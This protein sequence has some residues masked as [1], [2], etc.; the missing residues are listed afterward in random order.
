[1]EAIRKQ[2]VGHFNDVET[3]LFCDETKFSVN[4]GNH[5][6]AIIYLAIA[7]HKSQA[8][9]LSEALRSIL[10]IHQVKA[11]V[12]HATKIFN[13][14]SPRL[15]LMTDLTDCIIE[16]KLHCFCFKYD[17]DLLFEMTKRLEYL[18]SDIHHF[19]R[20]E[21]QAL[22]YFITFFNTFLIYDKPQ[23]LKPQ[24]V[25]FFDKNVYGK[26][27]TEDFDLPKDIY[28]IKR[29]C[30]TDKSNLPLLALPDFFGYVF[31]KAK[32]SQ[33]KAAAN[34]PSLETSPNAIKCYDSLLKIQEAQL[35]HYLDME[36]KLDQY[37]EL[38]LSHYSDNT[39]KE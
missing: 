1:M 29:L 5:D 33:N 10:Q 4:D 34:D 32:L 8:K 38:I 27:E 23:L 39:G 6:N 16:Y 31:R 13:N 3:I 2:F 28:V 20:A 14:R 26:H 7:I 35:F 21:Y 22:F 9:I 18:N 25:M 30:F 19:N 17:K 11:P 36:E 12:F 15:E 37:S 24:M